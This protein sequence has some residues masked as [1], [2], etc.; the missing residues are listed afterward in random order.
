M[1]RRVLS[2]KTAR[3]RDANEMSEPAL[4]CL[5]QT[6]PDGGKSKCKAPGVESALPD[7][8][9]SETATWLHVG[10]GGAVGGPDRG[11]LRE[12]TAVILCVIGS[13]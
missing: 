1:V 7:Q 6:A 5:L 4:G 2:Q 8:R 12:D 13:L 3:A 9:N 11:G 10:A